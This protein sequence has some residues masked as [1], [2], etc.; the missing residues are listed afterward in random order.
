[1]FND[2][3]SYLELKDDESFFLE[4]TAYEAGFLETID[5]NNYDVV[6]NDVFFNVNIIHL[7]DGFNF[8]VNDFRLRIQEAESY[9]DMEIKYPNGFVRFYDDDLS[10]T[11]MCRTELISRM[12]SLLPLVNLGEIQFLI[13]LP[14]LPKK[15]LSVLP[16]LNFQYRAYAKS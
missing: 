13:S 11:L 5:Q 10:V 4:V 15:K 1:M 9:S 14:V 3:P 8:P 12:I 7:E 2:A 16:V 6:T